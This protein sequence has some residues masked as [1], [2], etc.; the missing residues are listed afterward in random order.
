MDQR[1]VVACAARGAA[2]REE[3]MLGTRIPPTCSYG[4]TA[5]VSRNSVLLP[6]RQGYSKVYTVL[7]CRATRRDLNHEAERQQHL[8][9]EKS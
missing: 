1:R 2:D 4:R 3:S 7:S 8:E 9:A 6:S 5:S